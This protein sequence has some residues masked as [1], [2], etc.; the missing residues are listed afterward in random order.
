MSSFNLDDINVLDKYTSILEDIDPIKTQGIVV[1]VKGLLIESLG[2]ITKVGDIC[3]INL[4]N[5]KTICAEVIGFRSNYIQ[6]MAMGNM[7]GIINGSR[8]ISRHSSLSISISEE[9]IGRVVNALGEPADGRSFGCL[10]EKRSIFA[11]PPNYYKRKSI[12]EV[13]SVGVQ[14]IDGLLTVGKGQRIGI[15]SGSGVGKSTLLAMI[16]KNTQAD[17]NVVALTGE[18]GREVNEF[19]KND[20]GEEGMK[21]TIVVVATS[22]QSPLSKV[23]SVY[24]A[25]TIAEYF[26]D[27]GK[28]VLLMV[29]SITRLALA[30]RE[31]GSSLGEPPTTRAYTP[32]VFN[33]LPKITERAGVSDKG[34]I[35]AFYTI[36]SEG[37]DIDEPISDFM[38]GILDGHIILSRKK[39][40][41]NHYPAIEVNQSISRLSINVCS[42]KHYAAIGKMKEYLSAYEE[43]EDLIQIGAYTRGSNPPADMAISKIE[44][45]N[46]FL[47]QSIHEKPSFEESVNQLLIILGMEKSSSS[48]LDSLFG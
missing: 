5:G 48:Q 7:E 25:T 37:D 2:P 46:Q 15:F 17:I 18:R 19:I 10:S 23:R 31:I 34:S 44:Q 45:I 38:R 20:L 1:S 33:I 47:K 43:V 26:R 35:T 6:L 22:D 27:K 32:S 9:F 8:V 11:E 14:A 36:L 29:D 39:A 4:T 3:D 13:L 30:Q 16:A 12:T 24:T 41:K 42:E 40:N 21:K 28:H